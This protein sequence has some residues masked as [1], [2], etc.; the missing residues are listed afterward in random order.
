MKKSVVKLGLKEMPVEVKIELGRRVIKEMTGNPNFISPSPALSEI[1]TATDSME[2]SFNEAAAGGMLDTATLH[3]KEEAWDKLM[4]ALGNYVDNIARGSA[5][6]I[7]SAGMETK[8]QGSPVGT[9]GKVYG[10][11]ATSVKSGELKLSWNE[12]Y[13]KLIY[14]GYIKI[15]GQ[16]DEQYK[17]VI[18]SSRRTATVTG[19]KSGTC[20]CIVIE[21]V[22]SAG[23][24][25]L[26]DVAMSFIL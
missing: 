8:K 15:E 17:L 19:L 20:Y 25:A 5:T 23:T 10:V 6:I 3:E 9:P 16:G 21:A 12:V 26:S 18:K 14:L 7:L 2:V 11:I 22:G 13:G 24:G 1:K 4:T